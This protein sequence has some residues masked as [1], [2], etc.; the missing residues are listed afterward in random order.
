MSCPLRS[1]PAYLLKGRPPE[2]GEVAQGGF[3]ASAFAKASAS[4][5]VGSNAE[6]CVRVTL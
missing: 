3:K 2:P 4:W 6:V 1:R 5:E